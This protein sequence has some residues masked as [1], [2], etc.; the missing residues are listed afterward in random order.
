M[1]NVPDQFVIGGVKD[2]MQRDRQFDHP[3]ACAK[4]AACDSDRVDRL[5]PQFI[6]NLSKMPC[7]DTAQ[8]VRA[9]YRIEDVAGSVYQ[10]LIFGRRHA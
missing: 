2:V 8:I 4:V 5:R 9:L 1:A 3:E 6:R 7:I 10:E